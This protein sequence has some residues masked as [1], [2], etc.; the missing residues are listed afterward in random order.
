MEF[1]YMKQDM[2]IGGFNRGV[3][4]IEPG[5]AP[6]WRPSKKEQSISV[7]SEPFILLDDVLIYPPGNV[8]LEIPTFDDLYKLKKLIVGQIK[9]FHVPDGLNVYKVSDELTIARMV[10]K[11]RLDAGFMN[12]FVAIFYQQK[13][14]YKYGVSPPYAS[15]P[16]SMRIHHNR[17]KWLT[18]INEA[19]IR[20]KKD[21]TLRQIIEHYVSGANKWKI[22]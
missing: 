3:I 20:F 13:N 17:K 7:F 10:D 22:P 11:R 16:V 5:I 2:L 15:T 21:G 8:V 4:D 1:H 12:A 19:I 14:G 18:P 6:S 9:G